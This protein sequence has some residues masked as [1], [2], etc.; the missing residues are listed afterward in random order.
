MQDLSQSTKIEDRILAFKKRL[1][2]LDNLKK[3]QE[4]Y[5]PGKWPGYSNFDKAFELPPYNPEQDYD[6]TTALDDFI[7][8]V[9]LTLNLQRQN[10]FKIE[11]DDYLNIPASFDIETSSFYDNRGRKTAIMYIWQMGIAGVTLYGRDWESWHYALSKCLVALGC[12]EHRKLVIYVHNLSYEFQFFRKHF[13]WAKVFALKKRKVL[14]AIPEGLVGLEFRCSYLLAN[15]GLAHVGN[16]LCTTY[17]VKKM[18]GDLDYSLIR[19]S[20]TPLTAEEL[21]YCFNDVRV[22][23][24]YIQQKIE[25][26]KGI[27]NIPLTNT[28]YVRRHSRNYCM[29]TEQKSIKY[30]HLMDSLQVKTEEEYD[31][32]KRAFMGGFTHTGVLHSNRIRENV[33]SADLTSS[34][35]AEIVGSYMPMSSAI[36]I[37]IPKSKEQFIKCLEKYCCIFDVKFYNLMPAVEYENYLSISRCI[38]EDATVNN[39][40]IVS[41]KECLTTL[42]ELD[43]DIVS[44]LY[45]WDTIEVA[46]LRCYVR[47]Y[48]PRDLILAVLDLYVNKTKLKGIPEEAVEYM[49]SKNMVNASFGMMVTDIIRPQ[50]E[51]NEND[52]WI[53]AETLKSR[54]LEDYNK[55][56]N[57]FLYYTWGVY[58]TAHARHNLFEAIMEFGNDYIYADTDSI[59]GI[60]FEQHLEFFE[61]YN[62]RNRE[63]ML[64]MCETMNIPFEKVCPKSKDGEEH[65]LGN[66]DIEKSYRY[67]KA[68]GAKRYMYIYEDEELSLT[69]AGL[70]KKVAI[71][72]LLDAYGGNKMK[73]LDAFEDG[74][75]IPPGY[76]GKQT[77]TYIDDEREGEVEDYL[78]NKA[79]YFE[80]SAAH[81]EPQG[82]VM[83]QTDEYLKLLAGVEQDPLR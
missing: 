62:R 13:D 70:N 55:N 82:F 9:N 52:E 37:G 58:V 49:R 47:G 19:N 39:G 32:N 46:N 10:G 34:Y 30:H 38:A 45:T 23:M 28:G 1:V 5:A 77:L 83:S 31:Q 11:D 20:K 27:K 2:K 73:I 50:Y 74:F 64:K 79:Y 78:G 29:N 36:F 14:Q 53:T 22:I 25:E 18:V 56:F 59:K 65:L 17:P 15:A 75:W 71:P 43:F 69:V 81:M 16:K 67:F 42:T 33:G 60:N 4:Y 44:K 24:S 12:S 63:R 40:R 3:E 8:Q 66:W 26:D 68:C 48:L 35:P 76:S 61:D 80:E 6:D 72:Y 7:Y 57:R 51:I 41:A 21:Q 54:Q